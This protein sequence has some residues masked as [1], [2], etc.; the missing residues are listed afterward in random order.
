ML[1]ASADGFKLLLLLLSLTP[2]L[3]LPL[4]AA[5][6]VAEL[7][8]ARKPVRVKLGSCLASMPCPSSEVTLFV[9]Q[10]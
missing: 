4:Q 6:A 10:S 2:L 5:A 7:S 3:V 8:T 1:T 9:L